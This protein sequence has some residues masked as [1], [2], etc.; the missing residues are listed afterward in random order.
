MLLEKEIDMNCCSM[1]SGVHFVM[2]YKLMLYMDG[3][4]NLLHFI[5]PLYMGLVLGMMGGWIKYPYFYC[6]IAFRFL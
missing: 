2:V 4:R 3:K 6:N 5:H 1:E